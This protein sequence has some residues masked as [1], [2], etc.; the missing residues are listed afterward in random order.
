MVK[1]KEDK[2]V[3]GIDP[4]FKNQNLRDYMNDLELIFSMLGEKLTT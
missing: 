1:E 4:K 3:K 2:K